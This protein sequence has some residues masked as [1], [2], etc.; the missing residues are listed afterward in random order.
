MLSVVALLS[1]LAT[2]AQPGRFGYRHRPMPRV[3]HTTTYYSPRNNSYTHTNA[4]YGL[5]IGM[6]I[7]TILSNDHSLE[8]GTTRT[9]LN[10][11]M[12]AGFQVAPSTPL[13]IETGL[14]YIEKGGERDRDE[15]LTYNLNYMEVP[16]LIKYQIGIDSNTSVQPFCGVYAALGVSGK[17]K[18]YMQRTASDAFEGADGFKRYDGGL[19]LGCGLQVSHLYGEVGYDLGLADIGHDF[20]DRAHTSC[21]FASIGVNF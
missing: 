10:L 2:Q 9:G 21:I 19:R 8:G 7:S 3:R 12:A 14:Y 11:G 13:Y 4:Y 6:G 20:F 15:S 17:K 1:A 16:L 18:D 5:R